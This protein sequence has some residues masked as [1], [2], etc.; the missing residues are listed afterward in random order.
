MVTL[1]KSL[2]KAERNYLTTERE[3]LA[4]IT[5]VRKWRHLESTRQK[6]TIYIDHNILTQRF[7]ANGSNKWM[8]RWI[9]TLIHTKFGSN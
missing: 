1:S 3:L 2:S 4:I 5:A 6:V 7:N 9:E 8:N